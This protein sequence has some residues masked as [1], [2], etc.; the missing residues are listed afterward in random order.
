MAELFAIKD[1]IDLKLTK[2]GESSVYT[3]IDYLNDVQIQ[4]DSEQVYATRKGDNYISFSSGR[5]GITY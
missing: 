4:L 5:T 3:T 2:S 1:A